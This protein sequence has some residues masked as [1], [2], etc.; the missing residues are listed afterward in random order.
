ML[1]ADNYLYLPPE[2]CNKRNEHGDLTSGTWTIGV[3]FYEL[4]YGKKPFN[5]SRNHDYEVKDFIYRNFIFYSKWS[6][7]ENHQYLKGR[8]R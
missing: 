4:L 7:L 8:K 2:F 6:S 5:Y 3:I 1:T